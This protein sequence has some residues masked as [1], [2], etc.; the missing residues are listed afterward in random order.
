MDKRESGG[1][2]VENILADKGA[3]GVFRV[4][5]VTYLSADLG[6]MHSE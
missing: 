3:T 1:S 6:I 2:H 4:L 5:E